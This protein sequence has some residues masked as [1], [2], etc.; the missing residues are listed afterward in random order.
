M[1]ASKLIANGK[2][3]V[4]FERACFGSSKP[5]EGSIEKLIELCYSC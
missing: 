4:A 5:K 1:E 2:L 3:C